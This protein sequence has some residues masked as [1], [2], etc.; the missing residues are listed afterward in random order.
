MKLGGKFDV[1]CHSNIVSHLNSGFSGKKIKTC[2]V[3][4][5]RKIQEDSSIFERINDSNLN[6]FNSLNHFFFPQTSLLLR[7]IV[8]GR[9]V[10]ATTFCRGNASSFWKSSSAKFEA[11]K[12]FR[13]SRLSCLISQPV[14]LRWA[15]FEFALIDFLCFQLFPSEQQRF[16]LLRT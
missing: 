3:G 13:G 7:R 12:T 2:R 9:F 11:W 8:C 14:F 15:T 6:G 10:A 5:I 4:G 16:W 1:D